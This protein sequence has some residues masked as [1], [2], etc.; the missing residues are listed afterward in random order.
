MDVSDH[1]SEEQLEAHS[2]NRLEPSETGRAEEHL[3][4]CEPCRQRLSKIDEFQAVL[5]EA[6]RQ[7]ADSPRLELCQ[8]L[9]TV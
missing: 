9:R 5:R 7:S 3:L 6:L 8:T 1:I 4:V 2:L